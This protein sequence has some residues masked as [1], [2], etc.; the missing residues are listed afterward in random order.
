MTAQKFYATGVLTKSP[1]LDGTELVDVDT[2]GP[3]K[4]RVT[5]GAI[6]DLATLVS[7]NIGITAINTVG[8]GVLTAAG[9]VG[10]IIQRGG[11]QSATPFS[12]ATATAALIIAALPSGAPVG[13]SFTFIV[14]NTTDAAETITAGVGVTLSG[15]M[16]VPK[17]TWAQYVLTVTSATAV[18]I[19]EVVAGQIN[20]LPI[21]QLATTD[22][23][24][25]IQVAGITGAQIC[26]LTITG[27]VA[28]AT[29]YL[30]KATEIIAALP[31]PS[32]GMN[33]LLNIV[34]LRT[35]T[36]VLTMGGSAG[37]TIAG[38]ATLTGV[39]ST[40]MFNVSVDSSMAITVTRVGSGI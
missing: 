30:P 24:A 2:G 14:A 5:T 36:G 35:T 10:G 9:I 25:T 4:V 21:G 3:V 19:T 34:N 8:A 7:N 17:L 27:T 16:I 33:Y 26:S 15:T 22:G 31:S 39:N 1:P 11:A 37:V 18:S 40:G 29:A 23:T 12:D 32:T 6:A 28:P 38:L 13:T 20:A